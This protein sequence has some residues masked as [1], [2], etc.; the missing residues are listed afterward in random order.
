MSSCPFM[1]PKP[2]YCAGRAL[3]R[4]EGCTSKIAFD[5]D[6]LKPPIGI[7]PKKIHNL[8]RML[9]LIEAMDN[10]VT[11]NKKIKPEWIDELTKLNE[12]TFM[13]DEE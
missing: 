2:P 5:N 7:I 8:H 1:E 12:R 9:D 3:I 10:F 11:Y 13:D 6:K 4:C